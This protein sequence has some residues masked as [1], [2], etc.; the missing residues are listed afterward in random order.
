MTDEE[1]AAKETAYAQGESTE[2]PRCEGGC[3][4]KA[5]IRCCHEGG[6]HVSENRDGVPTCIYCGLV[7]T[8]TPLPDR[9]DGA[10]FLLLRARIA[11]AREL[12]EAR[13]G[14]LAARWRREDKDYPPTFLSVEA[15][16][17]LCFKYWDEVCALIFGALERGD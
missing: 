6:A 10:V 8:G 16:H 12:A 5:F 17:D 3:D 7:F 14:E 11:H 4:S 15:T 13:R 9:K 2:L 1:Y